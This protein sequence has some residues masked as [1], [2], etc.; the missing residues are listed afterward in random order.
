MLWCVCCECGVNDFMVFYFLFYLVLYCNWVVC[1]DVIRVCVFV[2]VIL[3]FVE[4]N[5]VLGLLMMLVV[6]V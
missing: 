2:L 3:F 5:V 4:V 1:S 6:R